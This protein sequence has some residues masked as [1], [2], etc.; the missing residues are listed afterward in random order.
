VG[1]ELELN[2][3]RLVGRR[4]AELAGLLASSIERM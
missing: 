1:V 3:A 2:Q 4:R